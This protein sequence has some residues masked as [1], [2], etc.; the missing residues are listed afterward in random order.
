MPPW[1]LRVPGGFLKEMY[2]GGETEFWRRRGWG[3]FARGQRRG[4]NH[5]H[6]V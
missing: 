1:P 6:G 4:A 5:A 3:G 2:A